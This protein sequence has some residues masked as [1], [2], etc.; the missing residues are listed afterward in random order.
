M[1]NKTLLDNTAGL[2]MVDKLRECVADPAIDT[3]RIATGYWD[4]PGMALLAGELRSFF[5]RPGARLKM[6][7]GKDPYVYAKMLS[8]A[9][10][11]SPDYPADFIRTDMDS[12]ADK[13]TDEYREAF[14]LLMDN[15]R[16]DAPKIEIHIFK[17][18]DDDER[19]FFHSKC[20]IFT[21]ADD[22]ARS[23]Y[24]I[25]GS[26]NFTRKGLEGNSELNVLENDTYMIGAQPSPTRKGHIGWFDE[27]WA[28]SEEWTGEFL[29][30][31]LRASKPARKMEEEAAAAGFTPYEMYIKLLQLEFA[32]VVDKDLGRQI[33]A[34]LPSGVRRLDY[35]IEAVKR[36]LGIMREHGGFMLADVVGLGKTVVGT[37]IAKHFASSPDDEG[38]GRRILVVT[39]PAILPGW[40]KTMKAFD[41]EADEKLLPLVDFVTTGRVGNMVDDGQDDDTLDSGEFETELRGRDYGLIIVDESHKFRNSATQMYRALDTLIAETG[42]RTG[43]YPYVGLLSATPQNNRPSDL[44]NQLCLFERNHADST[45]RKADGGNL[46]SFFARV[47]GEY[48]A[49]IGRKSDIAPDER[50]ARLNAL[51]ADIRNCVLAD[52]LERRTRTDLTK[53][54]AADLA[55]QGIVFPTIDGPRELPYV[56]DE[57]LARLFADTMRI[58][59]PTDEDKAHGDEWLRYYR[60]R[61]IEYFADPANERKHA[62]RGDRGVG[63][64]ARQLATIMQILLVKRLESSFAAFRKSLLNLKNYT[65]NMMQMWENDTIFVC[66]DIDVNAELDCEAKGKRAGH[67]VTFDECLR[68]VEA[69]MNRLTKRGKNAKRRNAKYRRSDFRSEYADLL[70]KD[71][72]IISA[73]CDRW[74]TNTEDPKFDTFKERLNTELF[75]PDKN[76]EGKLV[77]FSEAIDTVRALERAVKAKGHRPLVV[78]AA[79]RDDAQPDIERN[80][81]ANYTGEWRDDYDVII[82]TEVLA[83]GV[84]LHRA[85]VILN[86]DT[87]WNSTRLM[88]RIGRVNRIGSRAGRVCVFNFMPSAEG[89]AEIELVRKAYTKLQAFHSLFGEDSKVFTSDEEVAHFDL[90]QAIDGEESPMEKYIHEL[91]AYKE[92]HPDRYRQIEQEAEWQ[93]AQT[94]GDGQTAYFVVR[95]PQSARLAIRIGMGDDAGRPEVVS[96]LDLLE[97]LRPADGAAAAPLPANWAELTGEAT[98]AYSQYFVRM[99][100]SRAGSKSADAKG[101]LAGLGRT[102]GL[103]RE[104]MGLLADARSLVNRG[105]PDIIGK[106][107]ALGRELADTQSRLFALGQQ[108]IDEVIRQEIGR[109]VARVETKQGE[110]VVEIGSAKHV[111]E[112]G[113]PKEELAVATQVKLLHF[114]A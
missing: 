36:C 46:D 43:V 72:E 78:T 51:S 84:N 45:L 22:C 54:Y 41:R 81:D 38:R 63:D 67:K 111:A 59:A 28:Q 31:V 66:P 55:A 7:I 14:R 13:M 35:Q 29:E 32:D 93:M 39:P 90:A 61:A 50:R 91:K 9:T 40:D 42:L 33:E 19:Q 110:P 17:T 113:V 11:K 52:I 6:I 98:R 87:P 70:R 114:A 53:Y 44:K 68:D 18:G 1:I 21:S 34:Y 65:Q 49:L 5:D 8:R 64:V 48:E 25:V 58:I 69:K 94:G 26:S 75:A 23:M 95:A 102:P 88:Q 73:L 3:I 24:A 89:D 37:L 101:I 27:K 86:Y 76:T 4:I 79:N 97:G 107:V 80:F 105:N 30:Q 60:Y 15:C 103:A 56:M 16:G 100:A 47:G 10:V 82:T 112:I 12:L 57:E 85:N 108:D 62:G 109:L 92:A 77:I 71:Y 96:K 104:S 106:V 74:D 83:E 20:Y 2:R 99:N